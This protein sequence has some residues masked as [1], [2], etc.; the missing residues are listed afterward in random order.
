MVRQKQNFNSQQPCSSNSTSSQLNVGFKAP[1]NKSGQ[2]I[3]GVQSSPQKR[4]EYINTEFF[5]SNKR[6]NP[7]CKHSNKRKS[8][9][10]EIINLDNEDD[11]LYDTNNQSTSQTTLR[12]QSSR[13]HMSDSQ[14]EKVKEKDRNRKISRLDM[15]DD[16]RNTQREKIHKNKNQ[17]NDEQRIL[18]KMMNANIKASSR[19]RNN[20]YE[21]NLYMKAGD[22]QIDVEEYRLGELNVKCNHCPAIHFPEEQNI[23]KGKN[24][25]Y[26]CCNY[27]LLSNLE[28]MVQD[29]PVELRL[30]F[31]PEIDPDNYTKVG[32]LH[33]DFKKNIRALNSSFSCASLGCMRFKFTDK[34]IPIFKIQ[35]AV[36]HSYNIIAQTENND[37]LPTNG[38]LYFIDTDQAI[39]HRINALDA[40]NNTNSNKTIELIAYIETYL[41]DHYIYSQSYEMMKN[42]YEEAV[43]NAI[44]SGTE[45]PD[46]TM[47][48]DIRK[49]VDL[50]R[51]NVPR[52]NE[53]CAIIWRDA[54][55]DIPAANIVVHAKGTKKLQTI[56]PL[57]P[58]VEPLCYPLFYPDSYKGWNYGL[59]NLVGKNISLC[60]FTKYKMFFSN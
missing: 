49:D 15:S 23:K 5:E 13:S 28:E 19:Q 50:R 9:E 39:D 14:K 3:E 11:F 24:E 29:Y 36:Y 16:E 12:K 52:S 43:E 58:F 8:L 10:I 7:V 46:I 44:E 54:N 41:R 27:G 1:E 40:Y 57:S 20:E 48:F 37:E 38:Q 32:E 2:L 53:V 25:F 30:L 22:I 56:Y 17:M 18:L 55:D 59:K 21:G 47:L 42:V 33:N 35:G 6:I 45:I 34:T 26:D 4:N 31:T 60:D 51:Y